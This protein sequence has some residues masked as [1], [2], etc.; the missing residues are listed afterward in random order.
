MIGI[1]AALSVEARCLVGRT[2]APNERVQLPGSNGWIQLCGIGRGKALRAAQSLLEAGATAL[3]SWGTAGGLDPE[4]SAGT[5]VLPQQVIGAD[6]RVFPVDE[7]W[8]S[9]L[10]QRVSGHVATCSG[11]L[12]ESLS[13]FTHPSQKQSMAKQPRAVAVDMESAAIGQVANRG[14]VPFIVVRAIV[15]QAI[16]PIPSSAMSAVDEYGRL[17]IMPLVAALLTHPGHLPALIALARAFRA[18]QKTLSTVARHAGP[19]L[20]IE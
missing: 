17:Q 8:R 15:D 2:L 16:T 5:L 18:A 14:R 6:R 10:E 19:G 20:G 9:R 1:V 12:L 13:V 11:L 3:L 7:A 4:L